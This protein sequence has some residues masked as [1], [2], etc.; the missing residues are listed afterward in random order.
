[1][2]QVELAL[3]QAARSLDAIVRASSCICA[4]VFF[5]RR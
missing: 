5:L 2:A 3:G 1:V 4:G